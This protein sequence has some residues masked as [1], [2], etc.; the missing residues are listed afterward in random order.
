VSTTEGNVLHFAPACPLNIFESS[1][2]HKYYSDVHT[3]DVEEV[4]AGKGNTERGNATKEEWV[5]RMRNSLSYPVNIGESHR[6]RVDRSTDPPSNHSERGSGSGSPWYL[7]RLFCIVQVTPLH[8]FT[9]K[10]EDIPEG[11]HSPTKRERGGERKGEGEGTALSDDSDCPRPRPLSYQVMMPLSDPCMSELVRA[12]LCAEEPSVARSLDA[13]QLLPD[14]ACCRIS[15]TP[16]HDESLSPRSSPR[17]HDHCHPS[18]HH[19]D[20]ANLDL[21]H[22]YV[23]LKGSEMP[24][25]PYVQPEDNNFFY[26]VQLDVGNESNK[27]G[28]SDAGSS[29]SEGRSDEELLRHLLL[30]STGSPLAVLDQTASP[31]PAASPCHPL[32]DSSHKTASEILNLGS[33]QLSLPTE[34]SAAITDTDACVRSKIRSGE[35]VLVGQS[36]RW[37][38][39][40]L[41]TLCRWRSC[42]CEARADGSH[43]CPYHAELKSFLDRRAS[44]NTLSESLKYMPRKIPNMVTSG[45]FLE[46]V[47]GS[48]IDSRKDL[49][50]IRAAST[51]LQ[52]LWDGKLKATLR[53]FL[54]KTAHD[55]RSKRRLESIVAAAIASQQGGKASSDVAAGGE[56]D[57]RRRMS[58]TTGRP[59][60]QSD[61]KPPQDTALSNPKGTGRRHD[62]SRGED[63]ISCAVM[64]PMPL[65]PLWAAWK[66]RDLLER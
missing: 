7:D 52:E 51:L 66:D 60:Q 9:P 36:K 25:D 50:M 33:L 26:F 48:A 64:P 40:V 39:T 62:R 30:L 37:D 8:S 63:R 38:S 41:S 47:L 3:Y 13:L 44:S 27:S 54:S 46:N 10:S 53:S 19:P 18:E 20:A 61:K 5:S 1:G 43:L 14:H 29:E 31:S 22:K 2:L 11:K 4:G 24:S 58:N 56:I 28:I 21:D 6:S 42:L 49:T 34:A 57:R 55:M 16:T 15:H 65:S 45:S 23:L 12:V 32:K 17:A 59:P 35:V